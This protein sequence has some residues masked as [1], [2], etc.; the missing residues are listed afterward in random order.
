MKKLWILSA[1]VTILA[2]VVSAPCF[3]SGLKGKFALS[4]MGGIESPIGDLA[5][6]DKGGA[7]MGWGFIVQLEYYTSDHF[8][9]GGNFS[10][11]T[12]GTKTEELEAT[13]EYLINDEYGGKSHVDV[14]LKEKIV[15]FGIF[16]KYLLAPGSQTCPYIKVGAGMGKYSLSGDIAV[17]VISMDVDGSFG[18]KPYFSIGP[19]W[20]C[21][22]S[23][24]VALIVE[25][26]YVRVLTDGA[27][28]E[29][30]IT[31]GTYRTTEYVEL[32]FNA[33]YFSF[34]AGFCFFFGGRK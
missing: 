10:Y 24:N 14:D 11:P 2:L 30:E 3:A 5:D 13:I 33:Q 31:A 1:L 8:A 16:G 23:D 12:F 4:G 28:G 20:L 34:Y 21:N 25:A 18:W 26:A 9:I 29:L 7:K 19:G 22:V 27:D 6:E 32:D 17:D 15:S